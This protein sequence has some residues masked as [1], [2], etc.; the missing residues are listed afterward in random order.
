MV[1]LKTMELT[2]EERQPCE[3]WTRVMGYYRPTTSFNI[4]KVQE[5]KDRKCYEERP[6]VTNN[7]D[8]FVI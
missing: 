2:N 6:F 5:Y 7:I 4:G 8:G 3:C 1:G